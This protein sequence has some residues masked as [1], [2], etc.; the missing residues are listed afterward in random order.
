MGYGH[1]DGQDGHDV[2]VAN[3]VEKEGE[4]ERVCV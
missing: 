3:E 2:L 4:R 1:G